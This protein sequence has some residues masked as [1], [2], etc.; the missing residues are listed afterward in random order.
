MPRS[1]LGMAFAPSAPIDPPRPRGSRPPGVPSGAPAVPVLRR[2]ARRI[3][4][5]R[6][7][8]MSILALEP[9]T[10]LDLDDFQQLRR[11]GLFGDDGRNPPPSWWAR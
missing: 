1:D 3:P 8:P 7:R 9:R 10:A 6:T 5:P 2:K 4:T 11:E